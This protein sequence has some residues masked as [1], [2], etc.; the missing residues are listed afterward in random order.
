VDVAAVIAELSTY[1]S[2]LTASYTAIAEIQS[3][4]LADYLK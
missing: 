1:Q 3:M 4:S 2:Q